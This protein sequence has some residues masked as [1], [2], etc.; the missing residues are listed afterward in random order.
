[1]TNP[2]DGAENTTENNALSPLEV[3]DYS[4]EGW[5]SSNIKA[6]CEVSTAEEAASQDS[7]IATPVAAPCTQSIQRDPSC[8][9]ALTNSAHQ[10][11][12][13]SG[14]TK[15]RGTSKAPNEPNKNL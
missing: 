13:L 10:N 9:H 12:F 1:M 6:L 2:V 3:T 8:S 15:P 4:L 11:P 14:H 5:L 7:D